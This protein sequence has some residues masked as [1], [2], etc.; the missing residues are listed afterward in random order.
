MYEGGLWQFLLACGFQKGCE[1]FAIGSVIYWLHLPRKSI[2][3]IIYI[4]K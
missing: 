3:F 1:K 2:V 4:E